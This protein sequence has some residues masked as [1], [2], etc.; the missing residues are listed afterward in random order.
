LFAREI[1]GT[2]RK[3]I[4][5]LMISEGHRFPHIADVYYREVLGRV[6][7]AVRALL[8]RARERGELRGDALIRFPQLLAAPAIMALVWNGLFGRLHPLE[9][10]DLMR[11]HLDVLFGEGARP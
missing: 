9:L 5:R 6:I 4:M 11:A 3:D 10:R 7:P 1:Y 8:E 2:H